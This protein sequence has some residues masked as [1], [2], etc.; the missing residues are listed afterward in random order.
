MD[1][2]QFVENYSEQKRVIDL[3]EIQINP[4]TTASPSSASSLNMFENRG[5]Y[6]E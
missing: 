1:V 5:A 4:S 2:Q 6:I 3:L